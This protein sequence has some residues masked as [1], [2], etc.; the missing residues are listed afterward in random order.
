MT[1][2]DTACPLCAHVGEKRLRTRA[3]ACTGQNHPFTVFFL[4]FTEKTFNRAARLPTFG[5]MRPLTVLLF[6]SEPVVSYDVQQELTGMGYSVLQAFGLTEA[7]EICH[8]HLPDVALINF[9]QHQYTDGMS[10]AKTLRVHFQMKVLLLTGTRPQD[11]ESAPEYYAGQEVLHKPFSM[12][13][14]REA[15]T[16]LLK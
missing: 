6:E 4:P 16:I 5:V 7:M 9:R 3:G 1:C 14:L 13:Q 10:L 8:Q 15:L 12:R 11:I 2:H